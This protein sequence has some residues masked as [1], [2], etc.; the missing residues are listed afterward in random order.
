MI[1][2]FVRLLIALGSCQ[3]GDRC[4]DRGECGDLQICE[5]HACVDVECLTSKDCGIDS[6]CEAAAHTCQ[7]G[8]GVD[9]DCPAGRSC[10][11]ATNQC[12]GYGC[13]SSA[14]DCAIGQTCDVETG[15]CSDEPGCEACDPEVADACGVGGACSLFDEDT[16]PASYCLMPCAT[17]GDPEAC[18]R[19]LECRDL[20]G[21][22]DLY[23]YA[24]CPAYN[25]EKE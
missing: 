22:G 25:A 20:S 1:G 15:E 13:R 3:W 11:P 14:L 4:S 8:C 18:P 5:E 16:N 7:P 23:C 9:D 2:M 24:Y 21:Q 10:D 17:V 19:G 12:T 6:F